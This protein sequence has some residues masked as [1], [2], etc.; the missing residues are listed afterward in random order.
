M[1]VRRGSGSK[2]PSLPFIYQWQND[3]KQSP[4]KFTMSAIPNKK[5]TEAEYLAIEREAEFKSEFFDGEMFAMS[6]G[7]LAHNRIRENLARHIGN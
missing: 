3:S 4:R 5:L 2:M 7:K 6:G 1:S